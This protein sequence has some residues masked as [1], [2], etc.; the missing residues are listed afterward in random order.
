MYNV[1]KG[2]QKVYTMMYMYEYI[3]H[4]TSYYVVQGITLLYTSIEAY[5]YI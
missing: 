5:K 3:V 2:I 1:Y 4:S